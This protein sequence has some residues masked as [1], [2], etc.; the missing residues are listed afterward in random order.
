MTLSIFKPWE[1]YIEEECI[2]AIIYKK[3]EELSINY[4]QSFNL[5]SSFPTIN[6]EGVSLSLSEESAQTKVCNF[7]LHSVIEQYV[8]RFQIHVNN[9]RF[10]IVKIV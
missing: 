2:S 6:S 1:R 8:L 3:K 7:W 4:Q 9:R 10:Q 5:H